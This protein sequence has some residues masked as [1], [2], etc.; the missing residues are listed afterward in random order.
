[1]LP[2]RAGNGKN[3]DFPRLRLEMISGKFD[4]IVRAE[5]AQSKLP[6][7]S[8]GSNSAVTDCAPPGLKRNPITLSIVGKS[9]PRTA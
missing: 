1:M 4:G 7:S 6:S 8:P 9:L 5:E 3:G 2:D